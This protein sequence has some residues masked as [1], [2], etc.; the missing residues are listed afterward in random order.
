MNLGEADMK[1][2]KMFHME[3]AQCN[4][5]KAKPP[6]LFAILVGLDRPLFIV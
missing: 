6:S 2:N 4:F 3:A 5:S 1:C